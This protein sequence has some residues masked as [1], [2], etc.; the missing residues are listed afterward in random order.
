MQN[1][2]M[3]YKWVKA[4]KW[5]YIYFPLWAQLR[6]FIHKDTIC[7]KNIGTS[8][9]INNSVFGD[10]FW[11]HFVLNF[12]LRSLPLPEFRT[13]LLS[14]WWPR[15]RNILFEEKRRI[16]SK[17]QP[18]VYSESQIINKIHGKQPYLNI[19]VRLF[20]TAGFFPSLKQDF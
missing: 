16:K 6:V 5:I 10:W 19:R 17:L 11:F 13:F 20:R 12:N 4:S 8:L 14:L 7:I 1:L 18:Q 15:F 2:C 3:K 9:K